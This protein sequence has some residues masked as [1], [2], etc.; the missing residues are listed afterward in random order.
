MYEVTLNSA[1]RGLTLARLTLYLC[2]IGKEGES[3]GLILNRAGRARAG[4]G[5]A[6]L[7][8]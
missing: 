5:N 6:P 1:E 4:E 3:S 8:A 2:Y 7:P